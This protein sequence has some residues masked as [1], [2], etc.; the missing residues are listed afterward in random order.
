MATKT[1]KSTQRSVK[2]VTASTSV[3]NGVLVIRLPMQ[4]PRASA[5]GRSHVV[6]ECR[7]AELGAVMPQTAG[8]QANKKVIVNVMAIVK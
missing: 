7:W 4:A 6:A 1:I 8:E 5:T 2:Y 3:E